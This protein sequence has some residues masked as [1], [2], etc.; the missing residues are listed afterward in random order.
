M[1]EYKRYLAIWGMINTMNANGIF[2][3]GYAEHGDG[4]PVIIFEDDK[5]KETYKLIFG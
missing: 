5:Q 3:Y 2:I 1:N 4:G